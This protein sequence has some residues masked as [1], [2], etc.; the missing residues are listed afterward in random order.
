MQHKQKNQSVPLFLKSQYVIIKR[1]CKKACKLA[2]NSWWEQKN[3]EAEDDYEMSLKQGKGGSLIKNLKSLTKSRGYR[4]LKILA[5]DGT[6]KL[7]TTKSKLKRWCEHFKEVTNINT[8]VNHSALSHLPPSDSSL[9]PMTEPLT[10]EELC[11]ALKQCKKNS[12]TGID[13]ISTELLLL[14]A[15]ETVK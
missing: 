2:L 5:K 8:L 11:V 14:G 4:C 10:N 1:K 15:D 7:T 9:Y 12:S 3:K 13:G 6:T